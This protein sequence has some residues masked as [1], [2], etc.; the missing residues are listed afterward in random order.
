MQKERL[1]FPAALDWTSQVCP[2][3]EETLVSPVLL[4]L[5]APLVFLAALAETDFLAFLVCVMFQN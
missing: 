4:D 2:E 1:A 3:I 5:S